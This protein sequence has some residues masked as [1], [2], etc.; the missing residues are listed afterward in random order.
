M[1]DKLTYTLPEELVRK[2]IVWGSG[3]ISAADFDKLINIFES[4]LNKGTTFWLELPIASGA[5][6]DCPSAPAN[7]KALLPAAAM[8]ADTKS[9]V[10]YIEDNP[11]NTLLVQEALN[12]LEGLEFLTA[13]SAE[14]GLTLAEERVPDLVLM[15]ISLPGIDGFAALKILRDRT[16][17][18]DIPVIALSANAMKSDIE[19]GIK[20]GFN[21]YLTKPIMIDELYSAI[22][23]HTKIPALA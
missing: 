8:P 9:K 3:F 6:T 10:L 20:A 2:L 12:K 15:D 17:T 5:A 16:E 11:A 1:A 4:E 14:E 19:S 18:R 22:Q 7:H 13:A 21:G 23:Q